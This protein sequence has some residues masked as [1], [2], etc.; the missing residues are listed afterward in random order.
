[1]PTK[2]LLPEQ[3]DLLC[4]L[5]DAYEAVGDRPDIRVGPEGRSGARVWTWGTSRHRELGGRRKAADF[6]ELRATGYLRKLR[7][8]KTGTYY[9]ITTDGLARRAE[10][11]KKRNRNTSP[12]KVAKLKSGPPPRGLSE[13]GTRLTTLRG[14]AT[15]AR[16]RLDALLAVS[17]ILERFPDDGAGGVVVITP[18]PWTWGPLTSEGQKLLGAARKALYA[19]LEAATGAVRASAPERVE[20]FGDD[21]P[22][23]RRVVERSSRSDGP[24]AADIATTQRRVGEALDAQMALIEE[25]PS[26]QE[27]EATVLVPDTNALV[28]NPAMETWNVGGDAVTITVLPQV[29]A[30]LDSKKMDRAVGEK[31]DGLIRRFKEYDRRG[32]TLEGVPLAGKTS[33]REVAQAPSFDGT[34]SWLS[35]SNADDRILGGALELA[36][37]EL[38]SRIVL[39]TRDRNMQNKARRLGL[40]YIDAEEL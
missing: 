7:Q 37:R 25:L 21:E 24:P 31:A 11:V 19:W 16:A 10:I 30:E 2:S 29:I 39:V 13:A 28:F 22:V 27:P 9:A 35:K 3:E 20:D 23:L 6:A 1:V 4:E 14:L 12:P 34:P 17:S 18:H 32:N 26:S 40:P 33:F 15:E 8:D 5:V 36:Q 38:T